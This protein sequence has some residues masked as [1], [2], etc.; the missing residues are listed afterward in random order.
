MTT[1]NDSLPAV[2]LTGLFGL[3]L[4]PDYIGCPLVT[5]TAVHRN[6]AWM[7]RLYGSNRLAEHKTKEDAASW[8]RKW[9]NA[10]LIIEAIECPP[11][12]AGERQ[13]AE[14]LKP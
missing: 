10:D 12:A 9:G 13:P 3:V 7:C 8:M 14:P 4:H 6:G 5:A 1:P 2:G 11:N